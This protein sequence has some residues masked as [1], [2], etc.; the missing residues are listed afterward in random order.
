[1]FCL[2]VYS[3]FCLRIGISKLK[4]LNCKTASP[5]S[6]IY[7]DYDVHSVYA[8]FSFL[9]LW[10]S[11]SS[12]LFW[13]SR[14]TREGKKAYLAYVA[15]GVGKLLDWQEIMKYQKS[16]GSLFNSPSTT[17]AAMIYSQNAK[18]LEYLRSLEQKFGDSGKCH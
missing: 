16:N 10:S 13:R 17:A 7:L 4:V 3:R 5:R 14:H 18:A 8:H 9:F 1:M 15:E 11:D 2:M 12:I 6:V